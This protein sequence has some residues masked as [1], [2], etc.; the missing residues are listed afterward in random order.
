MG[1]REAMRAMMLVRAA[2]NP[3]FKSDAQLA[4]PGGLATG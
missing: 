4:V 1:S 2:E 3:K